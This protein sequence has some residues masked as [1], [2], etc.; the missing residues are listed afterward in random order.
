MLPRRYSLA[1]EFLLADLTVF[2]SARFLE[3]RSGIC[4]INVSY[5]VLG[6]ALKFHQILATL[7]APRGSFLILAVAYL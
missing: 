2:K 1:H 6:A 4:H 7:F 3:E 5:C